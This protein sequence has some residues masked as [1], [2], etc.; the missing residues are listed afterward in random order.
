MSLG[1]TIDALPQTS[2]LRLRLHGWG[3]GAMLMAAWLLL[4]AATGIYRADFI[5]HQ[6]LLAVAFTM[7]IVGVLSI[8]QGLV[9]ISGGF[10][11]L[12]QPA[13]L[14]GASLVAVRLS[15]AGLPLWIVI[16][17]AIAAGMAWGAFNAAIIVFAKLNPVIVTLATNFI[18]LAVLFLVFQLA[19]VPLGSPIYAFGRANLLG[20][21]AIWWPMVALVL[22]VGF[23]LPRTRYGRRAIAVG[24]NRMA[25][26][27]RGISLKATRFAIF[28]A[29]GGFVG[30][31]AV[32]FA[33][34]SGPFN[35][36]SGSAMQ[37]NII[38]GVILAGISLAGGRG[39]FW[40]LLLSVGFLSTI[41][42]ALVFFGLSSDTQSIFQGLI[43][44]IAVA[45][46]GL[47]ARRGTP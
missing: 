5:S 8:G 34:T 36:G 39:N 35:P 22:V 47:R 20:L 29:A 33:A 14:I 32:L 1:Q 2:G 44:I 19:E 45:I 25:A 18:G 37:L 10:I 9:A 26:R 23:L 11:D 27:A 24:G 46:D 15:E 12:S 41:P 28:I 40:M 7:S 16:A 31:A 3:T 4:I 17:G 42:T 43:L 21:P 13:G 38:A 6:T 30:F